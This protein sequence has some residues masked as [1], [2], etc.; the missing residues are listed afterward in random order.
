MATIPVIVEHLAEPQAGTLGVL[1]T[2]LVQ[3]IDASKLH[4]SLKQLSEQIPGLFQDIK[5]V[6]NFQLKQVQLQ[7][8]ITAEGGAP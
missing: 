7:V 1:N 6:G 2:N 4:D 3:E 5:Q 8:G